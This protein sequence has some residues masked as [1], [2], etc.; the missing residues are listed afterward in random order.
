ME[1]NKNYENC[2]IEDVSEEETEEEKKK[3][4]G[5]PLKNVEELMKENDLEDKI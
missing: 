3:R 1:K 4:M 2:E 5:I